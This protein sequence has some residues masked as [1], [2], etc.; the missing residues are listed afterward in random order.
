MNT[1]EVIGNFEFCIGFDLLGL[2][3]LNVVNDKKMFEEK[4]EKILEDKKVG[5]I[6][7]QEEFLKNTSWR[8][9]KVLQEKT[10]PVIV[11]IS[12]EDTQNASESL[13]ALIKKALGLEIKNK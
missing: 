8:I 7:A 6:I 13:D 11:S 10:F 12:M 1:I 2:Q 5:I 4:I 3:G 9:A